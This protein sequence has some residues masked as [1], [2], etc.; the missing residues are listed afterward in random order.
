MNNNVQSRT[1]IGASV[2]DPRNEGEKLPPVKDWDFKTDVLSLRGFVSP[3][4]LRDFSKTCDCH[5]QHRDLL[6]FTNSVIVPNY[7]KE[8][9]ETFYSKVN[10]CYNVTNLFEDKIPRKISGLA[11]RKLLVDMPNCKAVFDTLWKGTYWYK[12]FTGLTVKGHGYTMQCRLL[13][14][15]ISGSSPRDPISYM[16]KKKP[17]E[18]GL[19]A[20]R[21]ILNNV[22]G[23]L[24]QIVL[25]CTSR[26]FLSWKY[27][28]RVTHAIIAH[29]VQDY[30]AKPVEGKLTFYKRLKEARKTIKFVGMSGTTFENLISHFKPETDMFWFYDIIKD[31]HEVNSPHRYYQVSIFAQT[32]GA[33]LPPKQ[34]SLDAL[35]KWRRCLQ[36]TEDIKY[37]E[38]TISTVRAAANLVA[39]DALADQS[40]HILIQD[41]SKISLSDSAEFNNPTKSGGK[42]EACRRICKKYPKGI[43][44]VDLETGRLTGKLILPDGKEDTL[45]KFLFHYSCNVV[46]TRD[47]AEKA[48]YIRPYV[49]LEPGKARVISVSKIEHA[50]FL[51]PMAHISAKALEQIPSSRDGLRAANHTWQ[52]F[53]RLSAKNPA[54]SWMFTD[55]SLFYVGSTDL[56]EA[57]DHLTHTLSR[58][59]LE[60]WLARLG[61]P[62]WYR[63]TCIHLLCSP[64]KVFKKEKDNF[65]FDFQTTRGCLMGDP[66]VKS[67]I[68]LHHLVAKKI[69]VVKNY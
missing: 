69:Q 22:E 5:K 30:W 37:S 44:E 43:P 21:N 6:E 34:I 50:L 60:E 38:E 57:T 16:F 13:M 4:I 17:S 56:E 42:M 47:G 27:I 63:E 26:K 9:S 55:P 32:R 19:S 7:F 28:D 58:V 61:P 29:S 3:F 65:I 52:F 46:R 25:G 1:E 66:L 48:G 20:L 67:L 62:K 23:M 11:T 14:A 39:V 12:Y 8:Q 53:K 51:H 59:I 2:T 10:V 54:A 33:G 18:I 15:L 24:I 41:S 49:V 64:R 35:L 36:E 68:H 31:I 40:K 45:G